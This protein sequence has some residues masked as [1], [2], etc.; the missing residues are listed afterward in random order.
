M[1]GGRE[2]GVSFVTHDTN[3]PDAFGI[4][5]G[6][7]ATLPARLLHV[8]VVGV[9][10]EMTL[11]VVLILAAK[12]RPHLGQQSGAPWPGAAQNGQRG[13]GGHLRGDVIVCT[14][15][16]ERACAESEER[17]RVSVCA[18]GGLTCE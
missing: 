13:E 11:T 12:V 6:H 14:S 16:G 7:E 8:A 3:V 10:E 9:V 2:A 1:P 17:E 4:V 5:Q 18:C 15:V